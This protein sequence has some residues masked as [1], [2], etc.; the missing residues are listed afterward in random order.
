MRRTDGRRGV[1]Q[2]RLS[3]GHRR[4]VAE[5]GQL[6]RELRASADAA[7]DANPPLMRLDDVA[8]G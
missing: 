3:N 2:G 5:G 6:D 1:Q 8:A 4:L 7:L